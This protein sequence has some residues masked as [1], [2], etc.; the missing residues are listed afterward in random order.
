MI[1]VLA[2]LVA[3]VVAM[4][5]AI[6]AA[7]AG[8]LAP[9]TAWNLD[10]SADSCALRR[11]FG[12]GHSQVYLELRRFQPGPGLQIIVASNRMEPKNPATFRFQF[13]R[14]N[15]RWRDAELAPTIKLGDGFRGV[16]FRTYSVDSPDLDDFKAS[17]ARDVSLDRRELAALETQFA[18]QTD[19]LVVRGA[20]QS[21][22]ALNLGPMSAPIAALNKCIDELVTH[23]NI[24][25][26]ANA[27]RSRPARP[28]NLAAAGRMID[29]PPAMIQQR[30]PGI[31]N[32]R[33]DID[34]L[35]GVTGCHIQMPLSDPAFEKTSCA[36]IQHALA[37][38]PALD[39]DG[40]PIASYFA[41]S[42]VF[43][44]QQ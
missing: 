43:Q 34:A 22:I 28:V 2:W 10:Y 12:E 5:A 15:S 26:A 24:D 23:W 33:L 44:L 32:I 39:K 37:F 19:T 6:P 36:D 31:V 16:I 17:K 3:A 14:G 21:E 20:F 25:V 41:T 30:M 27:S 42:I 38:T 18:A 8:P 40:K 13:V 1:R 11:I 35:G 7:A 9:N 4:L 29:Y